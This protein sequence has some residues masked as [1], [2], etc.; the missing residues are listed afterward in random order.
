[1]QLISVSLLLFSFLVLAGAILFV[2]MWQRAR[3]KIGLVQILHEGIGHIGVSAVVEYP[4]TSAP[5]I[6]LLEEEYPR[7][8]AIIITDMRDKLSAFEELLSRYHLIKVNHDYL[9][10][11]RALYRSRS[12]AFRRVVLVDLPMEHRLRAS[13][14]GRAVASYDYILYLTG[15]SI[16]E[17]NALAYCANIIAMQRP[18]NVIS[19]QSIAGCNARLERGM[20]GH[21]GRSVR[22][23]TNYA[24]AWRRNGVFFALL[25][26][27][28]P[29]AMLFISF[30]SGSR[31]IFASA[32]ITTLAV[33]AFL[34]L[35]C[36]VVTEKGVFHRLDTIL[37]NFCRF[38][39]E[40][41][42]NFNYLYGKRAEGD[43]AVLERVPLLNR[44]RTNR[45]KL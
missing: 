20:T 13:C 16:V 4:E 37:R 8:E 17:R 33:G 12:R 25:A 42:K 34:Y 43:D 19:M 38:I 26:T 29:A 6:A 5:L 30:L 3:R 21:S 10:G 40:R 32:V 35:S 11:V 2:A 9:E 14:I 31:M 1:M 24:L 18:T 44:R 28:L 45:E 41:V 22:L 39:V 36:R 23:R 7:S 15:E 27:L